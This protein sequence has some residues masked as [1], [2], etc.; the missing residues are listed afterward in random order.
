MENNN[1]F[2]QL[3]IAD[4]SNITVEQKNFVSLHKEILYC[5]NTACE[6]AARMAAK[7]KEMRDSKLYS[8]AGF[9]SFSAYVEDAVGL[10]E[11]QAYNYIKVYE[12]LPEAFLHSNAKIGITKLLLLTSVAPEERAEIVENID[13]ENVSVREL[14]AQIEELTNQ[15]EQLQVDIAELQDAESPVGEL[16]DEELEKIKAT[17]RK[18]VEKTLK[19]EATK[20]LDELKKQLAEKSKTEKELT[21][22][23]KRVQSEADKLKTESAKYSAMAE[24]LAALEANKAEV[25]KQIQISANPALTRFKFLFEELQGMLFDIKNQIGEMDEKTADKCRSAISKVWEELKL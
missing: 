25:E 5:G 3:I 9:E 10:K 19:T 16:P 18:E 1:D 13:V 15:N 11:R 21:E 6:F 2:Q 24:K 17:A 8:A 7:L 23:V 22:Q 20:N 14:K 4:E 12:E